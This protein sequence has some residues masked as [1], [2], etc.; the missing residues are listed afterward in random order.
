MASNLDLSVIVTTYE[1][2]KHL[3]RCLASLALQRGVEGRFEV[4]VADDG[5][6]DC[7]HDLVHQFAKSADFPIKLTTHPHEDFRVA[8]CRNEGVRASRGSYLLFTDGDCI[9]PPEH[10]ATHLRLRRSGIVWAGNGYRLSSEAT[11]RIDVAA[12]TSQEY[13]RYVS[14]AE[15]RR[16][17][18]LWLKNKYYQVVGHPTKPKLDACN[19]AV[20]RQDYE[21]ING[22]DESFIGWG[23]EDDDLGI[24]L[25][26]S[27]LRIDTIL[28]YT[29]VYHLWH[30]FDPSYP[31]RWRR[32]ANVS[33][34]LSTRPV[35][36]HR[37]LVQSADQ[38]DED[39]AHTK[40]QVVQ[41]R[42]R[43]RSSKLVSRN[44]LQKHKSGRS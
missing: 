22:F 17:V 21:A 29:R 43:K 32:G 19:F 11:N 30:A 35:R 5:S 18:H 41:F 8:R 16:L 28:R 44:A 9:L 1:R 40:I 38:T 13:R 37:G 6:R 2:P 7:T 24:R 39:L 14:R 10:L 26:K 25:R 23:C 42:V 33:R 4:I 12:I 3:Q 31:Y 27:G 15:R 36:C 20:W 34:L